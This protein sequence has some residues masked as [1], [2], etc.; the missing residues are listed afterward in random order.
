MHRAGCVLLILVA[1][2]LFRL[3][4]DHAVPP[5]VLVAVYAACTAVVNG[6]IGPLAADLFP[7]RVRAS[8]VTTS[9]NFAQAVFQ[10]VTPLV[11]TAVIQAT[12]NPVSPALWLIAVAALSITLGL[13]YRPRSGH[14]ADAVAPAAAS[15]ARFGLLDKEA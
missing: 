3:L 4:V 15:E 7:T 11:A 1:W 8:G 6:S 5:V 13:L 14:L 9:Y 2:P 12:G 10:G